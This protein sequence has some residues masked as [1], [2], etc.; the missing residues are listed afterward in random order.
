MTPPPAIPDM[1]RR[2]FGRTGMAMP[3]F[4]CG[5]MRYQHAWQDK[6]PDD[7]P[8]ESQ[9][10]VEACIRKAVSLGINHIE[11]AR[12]YGTS[13]VQ[14]GPVLREFPR[15][16]LIVQTKVGPKET[17]DEFVRTFDTSLEK[18][19][20]DYVDLLG[21][22][23]INNQAL[24]DQTLRP[25]GTLEAALR[26]KA[27][28]RA[29]AVGFSTHAPVDVIVRAIETGAF[30]YVNLHWY[31]VNE[32]NTPALAAAH[33][34]DLGVFIISP[35]DKGGKLYEAPEKLK[36]LCHPLTPMQFNDLYCL[37][38]PEIHTLSL[39]A[40]RPSDFDEHAEALVHGD[41][42]P[43][44]AGEIAERLRHEMKRVLGE[45]WFAHWDDG[46]PDWTELPGE[47]NVWEIIRLW[48]YAT[49]LDMEAFAKLR[50]NLLGQGDHWFPGK[51]AGA[52][53]ESALPRAL[54]G[55][56]FADRI[57]DILRDAHRRFFEA[58]KKRL[59]ES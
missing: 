38:R 55:C 59:S 16:D 12:G 8:A 3:V 13:E 20:L 57:P 42:G 43:K 21:I 18:L 7:I 39:G 25:G 48:N 11:T 14:L 34:H 22:H 44:L 46:L 9:A 47:I 5:G 17:G 28:G 40:A 41:D 35:N 53:D 6:A 37:A 31:F 56:R 54:A 24:L 51:N 1:P 29:R 49:A 45:E 58:P 19:Q 50:Y 10:N 36:A 52:W 15:G 2:R 33:R 27:E 26:L 23:G 30:D 4:S 32:S